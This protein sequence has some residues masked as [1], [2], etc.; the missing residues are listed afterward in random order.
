MIFFY[1][2]QAEEINYSHPNKT[3]A[4]RKSK[5][6]SVNVGR[7]VRNAEIRKVWQIAFERLLPGA[8]V[9]SLESQVSLGGNRRRLHEAEGMRTMDTGTNRGIC[10][11][12][13]IG[14][15]KSRGRPIKLVFI[16]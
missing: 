4:D 8:V 7:D 15:K 5:L 13:S 10:N 9:V 6:A 12:L 14:E 11:D 1:E 2:G 16:E 3:W